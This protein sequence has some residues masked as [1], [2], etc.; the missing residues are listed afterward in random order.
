MRAAVV[1]YPLRMVHFC[2]LHYNRRH[3]F[4]STA[5]IGDARLHHCR[6][7]YVLEVVIPLVALLDIL[8]PALLAVIMEQNSLTTL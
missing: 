1:R 3:P 2:L 4:S 5:E 7:G 8:Y 6:A